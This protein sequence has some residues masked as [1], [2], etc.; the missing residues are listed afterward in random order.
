ME[1]QENVAQLTAG[2]APKLRKKKKPDISQLFLYA[3]GLFAFAALLIFLSYLSSEN[4]K[5]NN[6]DSQMA[7]PQRIVM[8]D[9]E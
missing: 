9:K 7:T 3:I 1:K 6:Q 4:H 8:L 5:L 2:Q